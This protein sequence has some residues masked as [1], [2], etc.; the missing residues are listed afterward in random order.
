MIKFILK[1]FL[2]AVAL[3]VIAYAVPGIKVETFYVALIAAVVIGIINISIKPIV[4]ILTLPINILTLG[5][6]TFIINAVLFWFV[7]TFIKGFEVAGFI[8][9]F[10]GALLYSIL[11]W[12]INGLTHK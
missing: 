10:L 3:L 9:A 8:P 1:W 4:I 11:S 2:S 7:G 5:L 6:F 12:L